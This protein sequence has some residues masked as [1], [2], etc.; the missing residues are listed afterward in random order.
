M[1][2]SNVFS[3]TNSFLLQPLSAWAIPRSSEQRIGNLACDAV[4]LLFERA[5]LSSRRPQVENTAVDL[6]VNRSILVQVKARTLRSRMYYSSACSVQLK[7]AKG[8]CYEE[9]D[10]DVLVVVVLE[11]DRPAA[12]FTISMSELVKRGHCGA[13]VVCQ[14]L[15][16][17]VP[18]LGSER[19]PFQGTRAW[20]SA[21]YT[22]LRNSPSESELER[23]H[24]SV[25]ACGRQRQNASSEDHDHRLVVVN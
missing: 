2:L 18:V 9:D 21:C 17:D 4:S 7:R 20:Q 23:L 5:G 8:R 15:T 10:F 12:L 19:L 24:Q 1:G 25:L 16:L 13:E 3:S 22:D 14:T 11:C 6:V